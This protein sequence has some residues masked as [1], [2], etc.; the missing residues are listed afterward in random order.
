[1]TVNLCDTCERHYISCPLE[2]I[3]DVDKCVE[4]VEEKECKGGC[5]I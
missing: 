3:E 2:P 4:Y 1:M 5:Q